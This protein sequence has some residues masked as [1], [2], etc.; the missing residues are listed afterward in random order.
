MSPIRSKYITAVES[1]VSGNTK[2]QDL[3]VWYLDNWKT[4]P[5]EGIDESIYEPLNLL[6]SEVDAYCS[7]VEIREDDDI[8][9][10]GLI[11]AGRH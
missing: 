9:E 11:E 2:P 6:F 4:D 7:I 8:D 10:V 3:E 1:H 5:D